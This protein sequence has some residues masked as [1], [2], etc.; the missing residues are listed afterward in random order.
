MNIAKRTL[1]AFSVRHLTSKFPREVPSFVKKL[2]IEPG[3][4]TPQ[5]VALFAR[6]FG[7]EEVWIFHGIALKQRGRAVILSGPSGIGKSS[8][9]RKITRMKAAEPMD[10][11]FIVAG[12][13]DGCY[14]VFESGLYHTVEPVAVASKWLRTLFRYRCPYLR[15]GD[16]RGMVRD[17]K[18]GE[19]LHNIAVVIGSL[20]AKDRSSGAVTSGPVRLAKLLLVEHPEDCHLPRRIRKETMEPV[21]VQD[22]AKMFEDY[23]R[24]EIIRSHEEGLWQIMFDKI[25]TGLRDEYRHPAAGCG[26]REE[27]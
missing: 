5:D 21:A 17:M 12:K 14:Y 2:A 6:Q 20:I 16:R 23:A 1:K 8:L 4:V 18:K 25:L 3:A 15:N 11:G 19:T 10:D 24:S 9:L 13:E 22:T 7:F 27:I 26:I